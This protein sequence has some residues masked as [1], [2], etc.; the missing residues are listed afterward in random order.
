MSETETLCFHKRTSFSLRNIFLSMSQQSPFI[1]LR[2]STHITILYPESSPGPTCFL[3]FLLFLSCHL[4]HSF[5][6][7][8]VYGTIGRTSGLVY[9]VRINL[10]C[11]DICR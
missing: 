2:R 6:L 1:Q 11:Y 9:I 10:L 7:F 3:Y 8:Y 4:I 5:F